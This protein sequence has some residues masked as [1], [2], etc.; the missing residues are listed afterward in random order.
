MR[1]GCGDDV[2]EPIIDALFANMDKDHD[3]MIS[4]DEFVDFVFQGKAAAK[5]V[6][7]G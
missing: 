2:D 4:F 7:P 5:I 3:G 6:A 1:K